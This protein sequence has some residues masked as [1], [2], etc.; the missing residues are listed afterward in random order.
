M[1]DFFEGGRSNL[2]AVRGENRTRDVWVG[3]TNA[4]SMLC[5]P[6]MFDQC[7][8]DR[9]PTWWRRRSRPTAGPSGRAFHPPWAWGHTPGGRRRSSLW[10]Y[11]RK[12]TLASYTETLNDGIMA[13]VGNQKFIIHCYVFTRAYI[14]KILFAVSGSSSA[15]QHIPHVPEGE[16]SHPIRCRAFFFIFLSYVVS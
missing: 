7:Y 2:R 8:L 13:V 10:K 3:N 16:G 12:V 11:G 5:L 1:G 9:E 6:P 14:K 4:T 15:V